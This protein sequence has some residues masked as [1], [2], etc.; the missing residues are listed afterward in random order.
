MFSVKVTTNFWTGLNFVFT[1]FSWFRESIMTTSSGVVLIGQ[2]MTI[3]Q[4]TNVID[5]NITRAED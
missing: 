4:I 2:S 3:G 1:N 5:V